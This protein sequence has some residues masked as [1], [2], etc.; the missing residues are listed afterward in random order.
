MN[1]TKAR[2]WNPLIMARTGNP[3]FDND[4]VIGWQIPGFRIY[5]SLEM[6]PSEIHYLQTAISV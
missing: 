2:S 4:V 6:L 1:E 5:S 3:L